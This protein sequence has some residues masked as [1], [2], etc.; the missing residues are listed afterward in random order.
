MRLK[1][2][3]KGERSLV[4]PKTIADM[5]KTD[6]LMSILHITDIGYYPRA[7][8]HYRR[9]T[10]PI[11][12][13][14][15]IYCVEGEGHFRI[16]GPDAEVHNVRQNEYF[17]LPA[18]VQHEYW[19]D[20]K[21]PWTIYWIHFR[22][23]L[24]KHYAAGAATPCSVQ[25]GLNSRI[26][27]RINLFE[28]IFNS[29]QANWSLE[30]LRYAMSLFHHYLGSLR[31]LNQYRAATPNDH[32]ADM[33]DALIHY[34]TEK[35]EQKL[36]LKDLADFS[37]YSVPHLSSM[38]KKRTGYSPLN[39]F[40]MLKIRQACELIDTTAMKLN[41]VSAKLGFTDPLYFSRLFTS[42]M[43]MSPKAYRNRLQA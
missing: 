24:A 42:I 2:G 5:M 18:G 34:M 3:F 43:G 19:A 8:G 17:I 4:F 32:S 11:D 6:P 9:R 26:N 28:E 21:N 36:T 12:Q 41:Q 1:D 27:N 16:G 39:Y 23:P 22:G 38:F 7:E 25:P 10:D 35:I 14:V 20:E 40:N 31:F 37:G 29:V 13:Y 30:N 33:T 15:F